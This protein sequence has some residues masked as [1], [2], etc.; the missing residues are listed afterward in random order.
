MKFD[1]VFWFI[2]MRIWESQY[3]APL[4][5]REPRQPPPSNEGSMANFMGED[6][7]NKAEK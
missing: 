3:G 1:I 5:H 6:A 7:A 2:N 4:E